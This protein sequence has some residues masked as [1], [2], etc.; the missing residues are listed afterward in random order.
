MPVLMPMLATAGTHVPTGPEWVHELKWDGIRLLVD[1]TD[2]GVRMTTRNGNDRTASWPSIVVHPGYDVMVDGEVVAFAPD[3]RPHLGAL[4]GG[5]QAQLMV[6]DLLRLHGQDTTALP[7]SAR[8]QLLESLDLGV[9][10]LPDVH[11]DGAML[12]DFT[13]AHGIEG[14]VSKKRESAYEPGV[15]SKNWLKFVHRHRESYVVGGWRPQVGTADRLASLLVGEMTADGLMYRGR[16]GSGIS[17]R[18]SI[19]LKE[20]LTPVGESPF[21]DE[22]PKLD[23]KGTTW[24]TPTVTV[25][26]E[27][28]GPAV[29]RLRQPSFIA[30]RTDL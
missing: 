8:R 25:D 23:A 12:L 14:I 22:V 10:Q 15:R 27:S 3:G 1:C 2:D 9:W 28:H 26:V 29:H 16:V 4:G 13:R 19:A 6:F 20:L 5:A 21:A 18:D 7:W 30:V 11:D 24:V 17:G